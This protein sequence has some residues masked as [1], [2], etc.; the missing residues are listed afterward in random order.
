MKHLYIY[1]Q[2]LSMLYIIPRMIDFYYGMTKWVI[3]TYIPAILTTT[4]SFL[5]YVVA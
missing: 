1:I 4:E 2:V 5:V 3:Y